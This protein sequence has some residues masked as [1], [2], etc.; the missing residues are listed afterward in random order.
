MQPLASHA[1]QIYRRIGQSN[2]KWR[3]AD[4]PRYHLYDPSHFPLAFGACN[5]GTDATGTH[6]VDALFVRQLLREGKSVPP[7]EAEVFVVP[8]LMSQ[9]QPGRCQRKDAKRW[10]DE[11]AAFLRN[12]TW[13]RRHDGADHLLLADHWSILPPLFSKLVP[14]RVIQ[15]RFER[16]SS[17]TERPNL[18]HRQHPVISV[19][20]STPAGLAGAWAM[21]P[22]TRVLDA[23][24]ALTP[25]EVTMR[26][27]LL[28][29][30]A[31]DV[32]F[33]DPDTTRVHTNIINAAW[34]TA[35]MSIKRK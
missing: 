19:A 21:D 24:D 34:K 26:L 33:Q 12:S 30:H 3:G 23:I 5:N 6:S 28:K 29:R 18:L 25:A 16:L 11:V 2:W 13:F 17:P 20:Y 7:Q 4:A 31:D 10:A 8:A 32:T 22:V 35:Q 27:E 15:G 14:G 1:E 9:W